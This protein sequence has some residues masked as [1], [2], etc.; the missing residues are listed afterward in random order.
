MSPT[1]RRGLVVTAVI[2]ALMFGTIAAASAF[3]S[4]RGIGVGLARTGTTQAVTLSPGTADSQLYPGAQTS[5]RVNV[6]NPNAASLRIGAL[7]LDTS[8]GSAGFAVDAGHSGCNLSSLSFTTQTNG[9]AGFSLS[10]EGAT[11]IVLPASL[12]MS[13]S[14]SNACQGA[15]FTVYLSA[16]P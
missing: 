10:A 2:A 14:A 13:A 12:S 1:R 9:G 5:V 16:A 8:Q 6:T 7:A 3:W 4:G 11:P 15:S